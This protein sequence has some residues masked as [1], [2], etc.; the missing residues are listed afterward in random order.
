MSRLFVTGD[1]HMS[2]ELVKFN[3]KRFKEQKQLTKDDVVVV[4]GDFGAVTWDESKETKHNREWLAEKNFTTAFVDGN[5]CLPK[6]TEVLTEN[7]FINIV[8]CFKGNYKIANFDKDTNIVFNYPLAKFKSFKNEQV[9]FK[10]YQLYHKC[11]L[12]HDVIIKGKKIKASEA[13]KLALKVSDFTLASKLSINTKVVNLSDDWL[14][15]LTQ[16]VMDATIVDY[17]KYNKN[18]KKIRVQFHLVKQRKID[19]VIS[20]LTKLGVKF[21]FLQD[22]IKPNAKFI[23][24]YGDYARDI[25]NKLNYKKVFPK[26]WVNLTKEQLN[27]VLE[28]IRLTD[29]DSNINNHI[30]WAS[31]DI[32]NIDIIQE[33]CIKNNIPSYFTKVKIGGFKTKVKKKQ[34]YKVVIYNNNFNIQSNRSVDI[35]IKQYNDYMYCFTMPLG[36][37]IVRQEGRITFTGNCNHTLLKQ[38]PRTQ[39]WG[40]EVAYFKTKNGR[41]YY[42]LRGNDYIINGRKI[43]ALGGAESHDKEY[44]IPEISWWK[45][46]KWTYQD[47]QNIAKTLE[48]GVEYDYVFSHTAPSFVTASLVPYVRKCVVENKMSLIFKDIKFKKWYFGH[49]HLD[50]EVNN[51]FTCLYHNIEEL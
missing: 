18:S 24:I 4:L 26:D 15:L 29:G 43:L 38:L 44:R 39:K 11:S 22:T 33:C 21:T 8:D 32:N 25:F 31:T 9:I 35:E 2:S 40:N 20:L 34:L 16:V 45:D 3:T 46:E 5:H 50:Q 28:E 23:N 36:N 27:I 48:K 19:R 49:Y 7:G 37:L 51:R 10:S 42:L 1:T 13:I 6:D 47:E 41:I 14:R 30:I 17:S 12:D